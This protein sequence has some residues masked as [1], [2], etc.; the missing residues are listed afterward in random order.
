MISEN[1]TFKVMKNGV[2]VS[3]EQML[4][5]REKTAKENQKKFNNALELDLLK[6]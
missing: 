1:P 6:E 4:R 5:E 3:G 2:E